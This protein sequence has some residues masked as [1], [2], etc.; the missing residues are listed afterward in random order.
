MNWLDSGLPAVRSAVVSGG[1]G[2]APHSEHGLLVPGGDAIDT[3]DTS[4]QVASDILT[5]LTG[6]AIHPAGTAEEDFICWPKARR[7]T[8][9]IVPLRQITALSRIDPADGSVSAVLDGWFV[10]GGSLFFGD[11]T[12]TLNDYYRFVAC[13]RIQEREFLRLTYRFGSTITAAARRAVIMLAHEIWL[14]TNRCDECDECQLPARTTSVAREGLQFELQPPT[15]ESYLEAGR[16]GLPG[17]DSWVAGVNP[18]Q[19]TRRSSVYDPGAPPGVIRSVW[20][21]RPTWV[22]LP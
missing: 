22:T 21:A 5:R 10:H 17:V 19:A 11:M 13:L 2:K 18:R 4:L 12:A 9:S 3:I 6:F 14:E 7:L 16:T 15:P 20:D 8:P 1:W